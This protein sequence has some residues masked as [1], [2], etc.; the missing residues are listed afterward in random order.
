[1]YAI[2]EHLL[3]QFNGDKKNGRGKMRYANGEVKEGM[4]SNDNFIG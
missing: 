2:K 4:W 1:V 3:G